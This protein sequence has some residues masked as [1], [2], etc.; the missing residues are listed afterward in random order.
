MDGT[1]PD[2]GGKSDCRDILSI[3]ENDPDGW[4]RS[5]AIP[6]FL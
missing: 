3:M 4:R 5:I 6:T 2:A 1:L